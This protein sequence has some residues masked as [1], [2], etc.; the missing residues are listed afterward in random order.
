MNELNQ[1]GQFELAALIKVLTYIL[2]AIGS[3]IFVGVLALFKMN[4]NISKLFT[5]NEVQ[6]LQN[7][8]FEAHNVDVKQRLLIL[9]NKK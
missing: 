8:T 1:I 3:F 5:H 4:S 6:K 2:G 9:E 7:K